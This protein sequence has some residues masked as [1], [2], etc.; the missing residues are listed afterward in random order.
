MCV[1][2]FFSTADAVG[3]TY[4]SDELEEDDFLTKVDAVGFGDVG[5]AAGIEPK[6]AL[7]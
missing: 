3:K 1:V 5:A 4:F 6:K 7:F 2:C